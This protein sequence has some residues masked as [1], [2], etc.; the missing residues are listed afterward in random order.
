METGRADSPPGPSRYWNSRIER[1]IRLPGV[2][3]GARRVIGH[4]D[5]GRL[6]H[7]DP[8]AL[9]SAA[10][11]RVS[12][13]N[14]AVHG[15][16][17]AHDRVPID[18]RGR[19]GPIA[20]AVLVHFERHPNARVAVRVENPAAHPY[21]AVEVFPGA[22]DQFPGADRLGLG[23]GLP[24]KAV[25]GGMEHNR[26]QPPAAAGDAIDVQQVAESQYAL[27]ESRIDLD[28]ARSVA[29][30]Q[31]G[32]AG[33]LRKHHYGAQMNRMALPQLG[34]G[35]ADDP[36]DPVQ[37]FAATRRARGKAEGQDG[38]RRGAPVRNA[39]SSSYRQVGLDS[40]R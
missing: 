13:A 22:Q 7:G 38:G 3:V 9:A 11:S 19:A 30:E 21:P 6:R 32:V 24:A 28:G 35:Q 36:V 23:Y 27:Y 26:R 17:P 14:H 12:G 5:T 39:H 8:R 25:D 18:I 15:H 31:H 1:P 33:R 20:V 34:G 2:G 40:S 10:N 4:R 16:A 37:G 29:H